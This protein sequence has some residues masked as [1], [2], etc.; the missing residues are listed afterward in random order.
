MGM[1]THVQ[2][3]VSPEDET[4][5][6]QSKVLLACIDAGIKKLPEETAKYFGNDYPEE[7]LLEQRLEVKIPIHEFSNSHSQGYELIV[8]E[9]PKG[10]HKIRFINSW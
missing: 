3:F 7:Y 8:S 1:S 2:G 9:I 6:K 5:I 4:Y 10:V